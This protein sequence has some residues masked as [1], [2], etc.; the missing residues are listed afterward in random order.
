M[1]RQTNNASIF[2]KAIANFG[3]YDTELKNI[4]KDTNEVDLV[5]EELVFKDISLQPDCLNPFTGQH[6][7]WMDMSASKSIPTWLMIMKIR[8]PKEQRYLQ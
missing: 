1:H 8:L 5:L 2:E 4:L 6:T 7:L 3:E